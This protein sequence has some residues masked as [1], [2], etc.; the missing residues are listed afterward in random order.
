MSKDS[1]DAYLWVRS[2]HIGPLDYS[3]DSQTIIAGH[4]LDGTYR[5]FGLTEDSKVSKKGLIVVACNKYSSLKLRILGSVS[6]LVIEK[7]LVLLSGLCYLLFFFSNFAAP[8]RE[9]VLDNQVVLDG[10]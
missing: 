9:L 1:K 2:C 5:Y 6:L 3:F 7:S 8:A 10:Y 4:E